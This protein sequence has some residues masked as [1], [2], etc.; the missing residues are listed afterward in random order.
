V[1]W[2]LSLNGLVQAE[3]FVWLALPTFANAH[4]LLRWAAGHGIS[5]TA[6]D[7]YSTIGLC[8]ADPGVESAEHVVRH[9]VYVI[10]RYRHLADRASGAVVSHA[11]P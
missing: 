2:R 1:Q 4:D 8:Y 6:R 7:G 3:A 5:L 9:L 10:N 11:G